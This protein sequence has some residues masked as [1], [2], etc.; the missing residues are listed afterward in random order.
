MVDNSTL[1]SFALTPLL[2]VLSA[3][4]SGL[5]LGL[6]SLDT[7]GLQILAEAGDE[8][9]KEYARKILPVRQH[10][11]LLLCTLLIGNTVVNALLAILL[12]DLTSGLY[13][14]LGSTVLIVLFGEIAPQA[15]CSRYGLVI[16]AKTLWLTKLVIFIFYAVAFPISKVLDKVL[17]KEIG[18]VYSKDE[19]K[20]L[21]AIHVENPDAQLTSGLTQDDSLILAGVLEYKDKKVADVMTTIDKVF[22]MEASVKLNFENT[23]DIYNTGYTRIP[24]YEGDR[25]NIVGILYTKDLI[26]IDPDDEVEVRAVLAFHGRNHQRFLLDSTTLRDV[27]NTFKKMQTDTADT[28]VTPHLMIAY[29]SEDGG[30]TKEVTGV[31]TLEDVLEELI[32][33]E[34]IDESDQYVNNDQHSKI[35]RGRANKPDAKEF[36]KLFDH[37]MRERSRMSDAEVQAAVAYLKTIPEFSMFNSSRLQILVQKAEIVEVDGGDEETG[38]KTHSA[39]TGNRNNYEL[40]KSGQSSKYFSLVLQ[41]RVMVKA[42]SEEFPSEL[43]PWAILGLKALTDKEYCPDF[44]AVSSG[45]CR[46]L[47][48]SR[49]HY[50]KAQKL[51]E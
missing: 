41:G 35:E 37:R 48:L 2:V 28:A 7:I 19:L 47:R 45:P 36:M 3:L 10:G 21:I 29:K 15:A 26:L 16:G 5:T 43:G 33:A 38:I 40:Y 11:N 51:G 22:M 8:R 24:I 20:Q 49:E 18:T 13:G 30:K 9:E 27:L 6:M 12:A 32:D 44:T 14:V 31:I 46:I 4:F 23:L 39:I 34:I 42:G 17:G 50:L 25:S 1:I